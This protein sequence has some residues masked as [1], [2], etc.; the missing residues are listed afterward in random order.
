MREYDVLVVGGGNAGCAAALA[1]AR[2]G[3]RVL[4]VERYG[5]SGRDRDGVDGRPLDDVP[6]RRRPDRRRHRAGDGRAA[7]GAGRLA[8][9]LHDASDYVP[10]ITPFDPE[11]HKAL[12]FE[13]MAE[14]GVAAVAAR[15]VS[16]RVRRPGAVAVS[17]FATVGGIVEVRAQ[18]HDRRDGRRVR[19]RQCRRS[20][21][22]RR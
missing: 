6:L 5:F 7:R 13:M 16:R 1:A 4:L 12:L 21:P 9:H 18:P 8:G 10:T 15:V 11:I 3:A 22:A 17:R 20:D 14:S 2:N 19:R